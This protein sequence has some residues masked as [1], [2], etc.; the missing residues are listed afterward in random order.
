MSAVRQSLQLKNI[1]PCWT[2]LQRRHNLTE[3]GSDNPGPVHK[4]VSLDIPPRCRIVIPH[5]VL[6]QTGFRLEPVAGEAGQGHPR[7][8]NIRRL[9]AK[10]RTIRKLCS[11]RDKLGIPCPRHSAG[12]FL[13]APSDVTGPPTDFCA[14]NCSQAGPNR[15][16]PLTSDLP[17]KS[18]A[19][20]SAWPFLRAVT[21]A[22]TSR[23]VSDRSSLMTSGSGKSL[24]SRTHRGVKGGVIQLGIANWRRRWDSNPRWTFTHVGFQ[25]R[26][27]KPLCHSSDARCL[28][29]RQRF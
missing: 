2:P 21:A 26:C 6:M 16:T 27:I 11:Q 4:W 1:T 8:P 14:C 22:A 20:K 10:R 29:A 13:Q 24:N 12:P 5:P 15:S 19:P 3:M 18:H 9:G 28:M 7:W 17:V 23:A 25:D